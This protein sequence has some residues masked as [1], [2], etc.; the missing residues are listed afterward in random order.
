ME[1]RAG[2]P[3]GFG[4]RF[5]TAAQEEGE[6]NEDKRP[7]KVHLNIEAAGPFFHC[8]YKELLV[9]LGRLS[10][11]LYRELITPSRIGNITVGVWKHIPAHKHTGLRCF[12]R[13]RGLGA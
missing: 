5:L 1:R 3:H 4:E 2:R 10:S 12:M 11:S 6:K 9:N 13:E 7:N 8:P